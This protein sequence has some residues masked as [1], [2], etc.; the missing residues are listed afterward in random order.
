MITFNNK[1][2]D[3]Y[4]YCYQYTVR[5][6]IFAFLLN[7]LS[8][9]ATV[10]HDKLLMICALYV[11]SAE[12]DPQDSRDLMQMQ[13]NCLKESEMRSVL[14][15]FLIIVVLLCYRTTN[16]LIPIPETPSSTPAIPASQF[17]LLRLFIF[18]PVKN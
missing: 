2:S 17:D 13:I 4:D 5:I 16:A 12:A 18:A 6:S 8:L 11:D 1:K 14:I 9:V 15:I 3:E 7:I 10:I